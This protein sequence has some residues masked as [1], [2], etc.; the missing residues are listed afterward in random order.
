MSL[1]NTI[2][3][4]TYATV[5]AQ[6]LAESAFA[7]GQPIPA[8]IGT[9]GGGEPNKALFFG[10]PGAAQA[11]LKSGKL[12]EGISAAFRSGVPVVCAVRV[13]KEA[14][15]AKLEL[16]AK[17]TGKALT[18]KSRDYGEWT[19]NIKITITSGPILKVSYTDELGNVYKQE[20]KLKAEM[21]NTELAKAINGEKSPYQASPLIVAEAGVG[22]E[23]LKEASETALSGGAN[24][25]SV[26]A[27]NWT[28]GLKPLETQQVS[29]IVPCTSEASV[30]AQVAA[31]CEA[32]STPQAKHRRTAV[33]GGAKGETEEQQAT[34]MGN[35]PYSR[36]QLVWPGI[37]LPNSSGENQVYDPW[38]F[39]CLIAGMH[40][41]T[42]DVATS[43]VHA[44]LPILGLEKEL[45]SAAGGALETLLAN[46]VTP[47]TKAPGGGYWLVD[48]LSGYNLANGVYR[49]FIKQRT[50]DAFAEGLEASVR[51]FIGKKTL[52]SEA[53]SIK[54]RAASY[55]KSQVN[56]LIIAY[57]EPT[58]NPG[59]SQ[60][61]YVTPENSFELVVPVQLMGTSKFIFIGVN[62]QG[63]A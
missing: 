32:M 27:T 8:F 52:T 33:Y 6:T 19:N 11:V 9:A 47:A 62:L 1:I 30:H 21:T 58:V 60:A 3:P 38:V 45:S 29:I 20:W 37:E 50:A 24:G 16:E 42:P 34:R 53:E 61:P 63:V 5:N 15:Q 46:N 2:I 17:G 28:E 23:G 56:R 54:A 25:T 57:Q 59:P 7:E 22:T 36:A 31:H 35:L 48:D 4:G 13:A 41:A 49:D 14:K 55:A 43:L 10:S 18:I 26:E 39:A 51:S 44:Y 12:Y 40:C